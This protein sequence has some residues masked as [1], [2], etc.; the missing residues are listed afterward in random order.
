MSPAAAP[1]LILS[2]G[3]AALCLAPGRAAAQDG[4]TCEPVA[5]TAPPSVS[6][7]TP[8]TVTFELYGQQGFDAGVGLGAGARLHPGRSAFLNLEARGLV[9]DHWIGRGTIGLDL[10][11]GWEAFDL[12]G[13]LFLG[14]TG[15]WAPV[16]IDTAIAPTAGLELGVG[17]NLGPIRARYRHADGFKGP[18]ESHL[19]ENEWRLGYQ[20]GRLQIFGQ[21]L[22]FNPGDEVP[23][24]GFGLGGAATF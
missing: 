17:V 19:T 11:G 21:Y 14:T 3:L 12:T 8:H 20:V 23:V 7:S 9:G 5:E 16:S 2:L 6:A 13:G 18:L 4:D 15:A 22:R 10:F 24:G 1:S